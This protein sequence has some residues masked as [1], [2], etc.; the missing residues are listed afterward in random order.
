[1]RVS[2][3]SFL[4]IATGFVVL[5]LMSLTA[6]GQ[7]NRASITGTVTDATGGVMAGVDVSARN[8]DTNIETTA[9]SN[10]DGIYLLPNLPPG[11]YAL[12]FRKSG[13]K[14]V[15]QPEFTLISTQVARID[16]K[17][18]VG[19]ASENVTVTA[20]APVLDVETVSVG[21]N[22]NGKV[23]TD[24]PLSIYGGGRF[25]EDFAVAMTPGYS[26]ISSPYGAVVNGSQW[27]AKDYTVDGT[28]GTASIR[29][30]SMETGPSMEAVEE[31]QAQTS[32]LDSAAAITNGGVMSFTLK[33]GSNKFHGSAFGLGHNEFLDAN[34]WTNDF[35]GDPKA[36]ARAWDY[37]GSLGGPIL[38]NKLFFFGAFERY[39]QADFT[40]GGYSGF[41]PTQDMLSGDFSA[42]LGSNLCNDSSSSMGNCGQSS[43]NGGTYSSP[44]NVKNNAGQTLPL[45]A[46][47][48]FDPTTGNQF[49]GNKIDPSR[50]S[51]V[52]QKV[53]AIYQQ[54]Y[55][56]QRAGLNDNNRITKSNSPDQ[57]PNQAVVKLDYDLT[58]RD[59]LSGS[60]IYNNRPRTLV[61]SGGI[62]QEGS[63]DGGPLAASRVQ[64]VNSDQYRLSESHSFTPNVLN[65]FNFTYNWYAQG[66]TPAS[67][68]DWNTQLG[69]TGAGASNFPLISFGDAVNGYGVTY[70]GNTFQGSSSGATILTGDT[71]TWTKGRHTMS[72]G[73]DFR[74]YQVNSHKGQGALSFNSC[75]TTTDGGFTG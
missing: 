1:M 73:G 26:P 27:F 4:K 15:K 22:M 57:T 2:A 50:F 36:K 44:I 13:F 71:V 14:E 60:W 74:A 33:S 30:N 58:S 32:G 52:S 66:D 9:V 70:I 39:T 10:D 59:K 62:W 20:E 53:N 51:S 40:L 41:V 3:S 5:L 65:V 31:L 56:A 35:N 25:V 37:G 42:L 19:A 29:G 47:M 18:Q 55:P 16:V 28:T 6:M 54:Y 17:M 8:T 64:R 21:T 48:I 46:G 63:T 43:N 67:G 38:K 23:V 34:T 75:R 61:D 12:T 69:F 45:Q 49:T 68:G 72:F 7:A 24:L 11:T